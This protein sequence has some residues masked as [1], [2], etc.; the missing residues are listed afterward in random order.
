MATQ[1]TCIV[2][3]A[4]NDPDRRIDAVGGDGWRKSEDEV[5]AEI[6][7]GAEYYVEVDGDSA[8]VE[9]GKHR[10]RKHLRTHLDGIAEN[11][12]VALPSCNG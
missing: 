4:S 6:E 2:P 8:R 9:V 1:I 11:N 5:I 7:A 3:D 10:G 12:L